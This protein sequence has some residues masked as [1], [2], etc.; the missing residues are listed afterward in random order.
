MN[1]RPWACVLVG[2]WAGCGSSTTDATDTTR[3]NPQATEGEPPPTPESEATREA[4][5]TPVPEPTPTPQPTP[6][7]EPAPPPD[8]S[9][10]REC[11]EVHL[12]LDLRALPTNTSPSGVDM[13]VLHQADELRRATP[14]VPPR[15]GHVPGTGVLYAFFDG[16]RGPAEVARC[17]R[18]LAAYLP[19]APRLP[20]HMEPAVS[21]TEPCRPCE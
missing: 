10:S 9:A 8:P 19:A 7:L 16:G 5:P 1:W 21:V 2:V 15:I 4:E 20:V 12:G 3:A 11:V 13:F 6:T 18:A 17:E 14:G